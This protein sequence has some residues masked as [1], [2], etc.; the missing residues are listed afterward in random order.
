MIIN[1]LSIKIKQH[2]LTITKA[3]RQMVIAPIR[4]KGESASAAI[5]ECK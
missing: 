5:S 4:Y 3:M 2:G 1:L